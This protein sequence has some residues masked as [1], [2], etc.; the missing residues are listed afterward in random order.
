MD[1]LHELRGALGRLETA[2]R[3][4]LDSD[5]H[6]HYRRT[7][8]VDSRNS[9]PDAGEIRLDSSCRASSFKTTMMAMALMPLPGQRSDPIR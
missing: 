4:R 5:L 6:D 9:H 3:R 1:R 2:S 8:R 7:K